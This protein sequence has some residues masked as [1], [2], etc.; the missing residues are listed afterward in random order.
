[1]RISADGDV[2]IGT[3]NPTAKLTV[4]GNIH[5]REVKVSVDAGADYVFNEDYGL[6]SLSQVEEFVKTNRHLPEIAPAAQMQKEGLNLGEMNIVLL[7]KIEE[8]TLYL[9]EQNKKLEKQELLINSLMENTV[10]AGK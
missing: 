9:I 8:L 7:R 10:K 5:S 6:K 3:T 2:G 1:M 4:A